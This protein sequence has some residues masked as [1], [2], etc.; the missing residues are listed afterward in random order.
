MKLTNGTKVYLCAVLDLHQNKIIAFHTS[1]RNDNQ[2]VRET[3][4]QIKDLIIPGTTMIHS[5]RGAQ[6]TSHMF[7]DFIEETGAIHSMSRPGKC[8]DNGPM[9]NFWGILKTERYYLNKYDTYEELRKD[10][11]EYIDF[12]NNRRVTLSM[13]LAIPT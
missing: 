13:G 5:D 6:Y 1:R 2:L 8:I 7:H 4:D 11:A 10:I 9:E 12:F 3:F